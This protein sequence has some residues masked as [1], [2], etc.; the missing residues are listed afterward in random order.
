MSEHLDPLEANL[1]PAPPRP[2]LR[3]ALVGLAVFLTGTALSYFLF[4]VTLVLAAP[5][6][7]TALG[8]LGVFLMVAGSGISS[9]LAL[10]L[11][12]RLGTRWQERQLQASQGG[13]FGGDA[14]STDPGR[15]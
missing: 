8:I 3:F 2:P 4:T 12:H 5:S 15:D 9:T 1:P 7:N 13:V 14:R 11:Y 6:R 10:V